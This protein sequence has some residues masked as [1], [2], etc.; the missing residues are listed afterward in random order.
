MR[1]LTEDLR[2][3]LRSFGRSPGFTAAAVLSLALGIGAATALFGV[4]EALLLRPLPYAHADRLAILWNRSPGLGIP[5]DWFSTAQYAD[6][7]KGV[8]GFESLA[9]AIGGNENL[10][11]AGPGGPPE[12]VGV[13]KV[14]SSLLPM[15]GVTPL[16]GR[17]F[18]G[19]ED[20]AGSPPRAVLSHAL[21]ARR[22]GSDPRVVGRSIVLNGKPHEVIGVAPRTF[23]LPREVLPT[24]NG[25]ER[26]DVLVSLPLG[27]AADSA[28]GHEDYNLLGKLR[29]GVSVLEVQSRL[30][31]L[32]ARLRRD[33]PEVYPPNG[34]LTFS[35]VPLRDQVVGGVRRP[36]L[37]LLGAAA[38]V[39]AISCVNVANLMLSRG[40]A[41]QGEIAV[42]AALGASGRRL[43]VQ[44]L[45]ESALL[46]L[47]GG[48]AGTAVALLGLRWLRAAGERSVPRLAEIG[49][50]A[51][52]LL[53]TLVVSIACGVL[54]GLVPARSAFRL[55][56]SGALRHS[57]RGTAGGHGGGNRLRRLLVVSELALAVALLVG[58]GLLARSVM[59][60]SA[61]RPGFDPKGVLTFEVTTSGD[62]YEQPEAVRA[63]YRELWERLER[64]PGVSAAGGTSSLPFS[65]MA[66]WGPVTVEGR[67]PP[68]GERFLNADQRVVSGRY[69]EALRI[70]L[71]A[72][73]LF[74]TSDTPDRPRSVIV[75]ER[76]AAQLWPGRDAVG[77]RIS[78]GDLAATPV[79]ATVVGV[80]GRVKQDGLDSEPRIALYLA[81]SQHV[82]RAMQV[83]VRTTGDPLALAGAVEREV[84][85][86][87]PALPVY[88]VLTMEKRLESSLS[89]Q[90][91]TMQLLGLFS[92]V[93]L[94]LAAIGVY[95]VVTV[96]VSQGTREIGVRMALGATPGAILGLVVRHGLALTTVGVGIGLVLSL[97]LGRVMR[98]LLFG[99]GPADPWT[100]GPVALLMGA[101][102]LVASGVPAWRAARI[103]PI[104]S[105]RAE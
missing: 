6:I 79:W 45:T 56:V 94:A 40:V 105:L 47:L 98:S 49:L 103:D 17:L 14:S 10:T 77:R 62:R 97:A 41:R 50:D 71:R 61:V 53:F 72:G 70:P 88:R 75:D 44:L 25:A 27:P 18:S 38:A 12:R 96:L 89:R 65:G 66:S 11:D 4:T 81:Q 102:A 15:L 73:R 63:A 33:H 86:L 68:P 20:V 76:M 83:V 22:Y 36:L 100:L 80:V 104:D 69:F 55:D 32:T 24:L 8:D 90:R 21:F 101:V 7:R 35:V 54:F 5:E 93:A 85:A 74:D 43:V 19:E 64:L 34:G 59:L 39:L 60:L 30:D 1:S 46:A 16:V 28:R 51:T 84:R 78:L 9:I 29:S 37:V 23:S 26:A 92:G 48:A 31:A 2:R 87:D 95:G 91:F 42:R 82:G 52:A 67:T 13:V 99:I 3:A 57:G 58:G